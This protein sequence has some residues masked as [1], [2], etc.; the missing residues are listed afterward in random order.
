[1]IKLPTKKSEIERDLSRYTI[2]L[3]GREKIGKTSLAAQFPDAVFL[4]C[5]PGAKSLSIY[6]VDINSWTDFLEAVKLLK[7]S[8]QFKTVVIDTVDLAFKYC[9]DYMCKK[10]VIDHPSDE[11]FGKGYNLIRDEFHRCIST[12][13]KIGRGVVLI[14][15]AKEQDVKRLKG[16]SFSISPTLSK[17]GRSVIEPMVDIWGYYGYD[18]ATRTL[19]IRGNEEVNAGCRLTQNFVGVETIPM[20][21]S[22][23]QAYANFI[24]AFE[25]T[26]KGEAPA[27]PATRKFV[28]RKK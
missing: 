17:Q 26:K 18:G 12:L 24:A 23:E 5:E 8:A 14:S 13:E 10:L 16:D 2:F 9:E 7:D 1:M 27:A 6:R 3:Y 25:T 28:I 22:A 20:G 4:M 21:G 19:Q 11:A 15:H